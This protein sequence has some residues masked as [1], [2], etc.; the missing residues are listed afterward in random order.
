MK[1][2]MRIAVLVMIMASVSLVGCAG[3]DPQDQRNTW[4]NA[5]T[6]AAIGT[7]AGALLGEATGGGDNVKKGAIY[8]GLAGAALGAAN[9]PR[10][11]A[12]N[13]VA[14][15]QP[16]VSVGIGSPGFGGSGNPG[17]DAAYQQGVADRNREIQREEERR[18]YEDGR[19]GY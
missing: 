1:I 14:N 18:A 2:T 9:T 10:K 13:Q 15:N 19:R 17:V 11:G 3:M 7:V 8:G 4:I 16:L 6:G 12:P 5:G